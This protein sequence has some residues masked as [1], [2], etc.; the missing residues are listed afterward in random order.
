[1]ITCSATPGWQAVILGEHG[2]L[3]GAKAGSLLIDCGTISPAATRS[4]AN[5]LAESGV[6]CSMRR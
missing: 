5:K 6:V 4:L 1:M 2:I 3:A